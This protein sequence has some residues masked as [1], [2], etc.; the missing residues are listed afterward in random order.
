MPESK[1]LKTPTAPETGAGRNAPGYSRITQ[2]KS[3]IQSLPANINKA[4]K[5]TFSPRVKTKAPTGQTGGVAEQ[6]WAQNAAQASHVSQRQTG[7]SR[8]TLLSR[9][10]SRAFVT[11][12]PKKAAEIKPRQF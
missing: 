10:F 3:F 1:V 7:P 2:I 5:K 9:A 8:T 12:T 4:I 11:P 6:D